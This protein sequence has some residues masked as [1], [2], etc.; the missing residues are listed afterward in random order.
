MFTGYFV[1][2]LLCSLCGLLSFFAFNNFI[3]LFLLLAVPCLR[4]CVGFSLVAEYGG[5]S[6]AVVHELLIA[7]ASL[8]AEHRLEGVRASIVVVP[9][10]DS[11]GLTMMVHG[12]GCSAARGL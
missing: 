12:L 6:F 7:G 8:T 1:A 10:L 11:T 5:Y 2:P 4:C 9:Q 3:N